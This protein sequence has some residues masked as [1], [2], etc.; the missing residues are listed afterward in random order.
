MRVVKLSDTMPY[1]QASCVFLVLSEIQTS[2]LHR[3]EIKGDIVSP[4]GCIGRR[5]KQAS[6]TWLSIPLTFDA[7]A[8]IPLE[9]NENQSRRSRLDSF[10]RSRQG[11]INEKKSF[12]ESYFYWMSAELCKALFLPAF[13]GGLSSK[14]RL[15]FLLFLSK[16]VCDGACV[17][18]HIMQSGESSLVFKFWNIALLRIWLAT[19]NYHGYHFLSAYRTSSHVHT[20]HAGL[21]LE[22]GAFPIYPIAATWFGLR[23]EHEKTRR[24]SASSINMTCSSQSPAETWTSLWVW[25][26]FF[27][28]RVYR[29]FVNRPPNRASCLEVDHQVRFSF[30]LFNLSPDVDDWPWTWLMRK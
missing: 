7:A 18:L 12:A 21:R 17:L 19:L 15:L 14:E 29:T 27:L 16:I 24:R 9:G 25:H 30:L 5:F 22:Y 23:V 8:M 28:Q 1:L 4:C 13:E 20:V 26:F 2:D 3:W 11:G 6:L 10:P